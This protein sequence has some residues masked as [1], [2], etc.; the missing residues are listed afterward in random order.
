MDMIYQDGDVEKCRRDAIYNR[1]PFL[2]LKAPG[3]MSG[4]LPQ[5]GCL[6]WV[7]REQCQHGGEGAGANTSK[8]PVPQVLI[9]WR[10]PHPRGW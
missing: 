7:E 6:A 2:E 9:S 4:E 3:E 8:S 10:A 1:V 5:P